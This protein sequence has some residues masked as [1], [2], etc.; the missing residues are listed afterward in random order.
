[1]F[2]SFDLSSD[3]SQSAARLTRL[4]AKM[5]ECGYAGFLV[6]LAD[7]H[8]GEYIPP[9]AE[10]LKWLTGFAGSAGVAVVLAQQAAIFVDGRYTLQVLE[11]VDLTAVTPVAIAD[12]SVGQWLAERA[13]QGDVIAYDPWLHTIG[14]VRRLRSSLDEVGAMLQ[15]VERNVVD[16]IWDDQPTPPVT[17]VTLY[18]AAFVGA[19]YTEKLARIAEALRGKKAHAVVFTQ[20]DSIAWLLNIRGNDVPHTPFALSFAIVSDQ[21]QA[22]WFIHPDK[23][24]TDVRS[25][26]G[27]DVVF[28]SPAEFVPALKELGAGQ[29]S[30]L[31]DPALAADQIALAIVNAGGLLVEGD[32]PA[33]LM[34]ATKSAAEL[35]ATRG[36]HIRDGAAMVRF[37][38]WFDEQAPKGGLTEIA[39]AEALERFRAET[40]L[41]KD[42]S[43]DTISAAGPHAA[44]PHY[45]VTTASNLPINSGELFLIDSGAQYLDGTTDI[46]R[47]IAVGAI[48]PEMKDCFTRVLKGHIAIARARFPKGTTGSHLDVLA[49]LP[50]WEVGLDF[51]HGT[52]H[53]VGVYLSVHEG[54]QR[55]SKASRVEL[56]PGMIISNE[57][58]YYQAGA[59]GIR[60]ENLIV[61]TEAETIAGGDRPMMGFETISF[62]PF[63]VRAVEVAL[64]NVDERAWLNAYHA[65]VF[66]KISPLLSDTAELAWLTK[67]TK[68]I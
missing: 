63:D 20:P 25:A 56:K 55:I 49:R 1:M 35:N 15:P 31:V 6:P 36:A 33:Q 3:F 53:G 59:F 24:N 17:P 12:V 46:T 51:D 27:P 4:R 13:Q 50:L 23:V 7:E 61:V 57:P 26:F 47:T 64:L 39:T 10:R 28:Q 18:P 5:G 40:G 2:Q 16:A 11:Q 32:D 52:G 48:T 30:V 45:H 58:G 37:L 19:P 68:P 38:S 22:R 67:A 34:K 14:E 8:Q 66:E 41:L 62:A 43:F 21:G 54:P 29:A 42:L 60:L 44:I 9:G 65:E